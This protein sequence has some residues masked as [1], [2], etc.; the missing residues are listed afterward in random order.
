VLSA[1]SA[2]RAVPDFTYQDGLLTMTNDVLEVI[3]GVDTHADNHVLAILDQLGRMLSV[4]SFPSTTDGCRDLLAALMQAGPVR[5]VGIEGTGSYGAGLA[6][7]LTAAQ[8]RVIEVDRP[9]RKARRSR[10]KSDPVDAEAAARAVL[11]GT[12]TGTPKTRNGPVEAIR[13]LRSARS[14]AVKARTAALNALVGA[15]RCA[16][17]PL[18]QQLQGLSSRELVVAVCTMDLTGDRSD[19]AVATRIALSRLATRVQHLDLEIRAADKDLDALTTKTAP[20]LC[21]TMG[22]GPEVAGQLLMTAGD[23]PHRLR[24]DAAFANLTGVAPLQASSGRTSRHRLNRGGDRQA[25]RA[26]HTVVLT[27]MR[28][29]ERTRTYV[30]RRTAQGLS[31]REI[32]R[33]LKR[34]VAR[35]LLPLILAAQT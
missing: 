21:A 27:R 33:C 13:M 32:I 17:Q 5:A 31:K 18:A 14:S 24:N 1:R 25:N 34:Y 2:V 12:A 23:N 9:N 26:L 6:R 28:H 30:T 15:A 11:A 35:E 7:M 22:V 4:Q 20:Q 10:G 16:V 19:P 3:G 29:D 8:V